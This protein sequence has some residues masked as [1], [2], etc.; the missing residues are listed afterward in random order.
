MVADQE[1]VPKYICQQCIDEVLIVLPN[2]AEYP[3][4]MMEKIGETG[5]TVV[6]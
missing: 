4:E 2:T 1:S 6:I 3:M 5:I